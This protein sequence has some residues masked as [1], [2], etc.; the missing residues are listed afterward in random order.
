[1][2][3]EYFGF[4]PFGNELMFGKLAAVVCG[5]RPYLSDVWQQHQYDRL[6]QGF[7]VFAFGQ[8][9]CEREIGVSFHQ[10]DNRPLSSLANDS[11]HL[12]VAWC[13]SIPVRRPFVYH[14]AVLYR[15]IRGGY[16][17]LAVLE[18]MAAVFPQAASVFLVGADIGIDG[19]YA[20]ALFALPAQP[21]HNLCRR[22]LLFCHLVSY[23]FSDFQC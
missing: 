16:L 12:E 21:S 11:V 6:S 22:P 4:Q 10:C 19:L 17:T 15:D 1:V 20:D 13:R 7:G 14:R 5:Y 9:P 2:G 8:F 23:E 3:E 18:L